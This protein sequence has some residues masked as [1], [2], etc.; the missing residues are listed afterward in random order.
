M[1]VLKNFKKSQESELVPKKFL[2]EADLVSCIEKNESLLDLEVP[3]F[4][5]ASI[6]HREFHVGTGRIDLLAQYE[7]AIA[8]IECKSEEIDRDALTQLR[9][10]LS[11]DDVILEAL[12]QLHEVDNNDQ[13]NWVGILVGQSISFKLLAELENTDYKIEIKGQKIPIA[14]ITISRF[15]ESSEE[16]VVVSNVY[17]RVEDAKDK[18]F[19]LTYNGEEIANNLSIGK[20]VLQVVKHYVQVNNKPT[21]EELRKIFPDN[22]NKFGNNGVFKKLEDAKKDDRKLGYTKYY[23]K[24]KKDKIKLSDETIA[25]SA[26]WRYEQSKPFFEKAKELGFTITESKNNKIDGK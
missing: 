17:F 23:L 1:K 2:N 12:K 9:G 24:N 15:Q 4:E 7:D 21:F 20:L 10:Y 18:K 19:T 25:I 11:K 14:A 22:L 16:D 5:E 6:L 13:L 26:Q 3:Y 8:V